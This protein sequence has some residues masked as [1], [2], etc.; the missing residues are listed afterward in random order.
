MPKAMAVVLNVNR[1]PNAINACAHI[2]ITAPLR[3]T[4]PDG[5]GRE[6][7]RATDP[8]KSRS[9]M[10]FQVQP[11]PRINH[12]PRAHPIAIQASSARGWPSCNIANANPHQQGISNNHVPIGRSARLSLR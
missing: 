5:M 11:A 1:I 10:S 8:S 2:Q 9:V 7:V 6:A 12:A 3:L 4:C